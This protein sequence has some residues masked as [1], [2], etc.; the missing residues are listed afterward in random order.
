VPPPLLSAAPVAG[1]ARGLTPRPTTALAALLLVLL[2]AGAFWPIVTGRRTVYYGDL[3][4][5][6]IPQ[7]SFQRDQ[8]LAGR[9]PLWNP[10]LLC[11]TPFVGNPQAWPLYPSSAL[12]YGL[13]APVAARRDRG[14]A[15]GACR[16][17]HAVVFAAAR[18]HRVG[19]AAG[20]RRLGLWRGARVQDAVPEHG[21]GG[22]VFA[23]ALVGHGW[24]DLRT[25][26]A[27]TATLA[28]LVGLALLAAHAQVFLMTF[29][30]C[31]AYAAWRLWPWRGA[32][33]KRTAGALI[34]A[35]ALG[36]LLS[37]GQ[38]LPVMDHVR[39]SVRAR[40]TLGR[41]DRFT[42]PPRAL[43]TNFVAP[44]FFGN[45]ATGDYRGPGNFWEPCAYI[46]LLPFG[47]AVL[48][49]RLA[50]PARQGNALL[51]TGGARGGVARV[52]HHGR[53]VHRG[54]L[55]VARRQQ[56]Q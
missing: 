41:A 42:L 6:F 31:G 26:P 34:A 21:A 54:L 11:G 40:L 28:L 50:L 14:R 43:V 32:D 38:L 8:L 44:N 13:E 23:V 46:G 16:C 15:F 55:P 18:P 48:C 2:A 7:L 3:A 52:G 39:A 5:Y 9:V 49:R 45:P 17:R 56:V 25:T 22:G 53:A 33:R 19:G 37:A 51:G 24:A 35:F 29:Y 47:L 20:R 10:Y 1:R 27:R 36:S 30:L 12:L 4:L